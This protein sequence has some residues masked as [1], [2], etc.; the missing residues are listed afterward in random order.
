FTSSPDASS[1][2]VAVKV[3]SAVS[4]AFNSGMTTVILLPST[5]VSTD[6]PFNSIVSATKFIPFGKSSFT[7]TSFNTLSSDLFVTSIVYANASPGMAL[8]LF[9]F[10][11]A[12]KSPRSTSTG[13]SGFSGLS[14]SSGSVTLAMFTSSPDASSDTV[15]VKVISAVSPAF[16]SGMTTVNLLP[17]TSASTDSPFNS[18]VSATKFNPFGKSSSTVT[19]FITLSYDEIG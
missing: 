4:P 7:V 18:I 6:S 1:D 5:S 3:I 14:G 9:T 17:S 19:S 16:N 15:A 12:V 8:A 2:T 10:F 11:A 13:T